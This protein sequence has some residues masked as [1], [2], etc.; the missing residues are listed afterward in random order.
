[1]AQ[2][3]IPIRDTRSTTLDGTGG[4]SV[5]FGPSRPNTRWLIQ[6]VSVNVSSNTEEATGV[7]Y[8]GGERV[9]ETFTASSGDSDNDL[10][11]IPLWPGETYRFQWTGGDAGATATLSFRGEEITGM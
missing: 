3:T 1:M 10:P 6:G 9:S 5:Q 7:L 4:G 11:A 8:R 2:S